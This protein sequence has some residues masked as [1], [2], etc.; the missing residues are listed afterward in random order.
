MAANPI[1]IALLKEHCLV[2]CLWGTPRTIY[3]RTRYASH[4]PLLQTPNPIERITQMLNVRSSSYKLADVLIRIEQRTQR[5]IVDLV[6]FNFQSEIKA[7][8]KKAK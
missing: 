2:V 1:N 5:E 6:F 4:R 3:E 7:A 8:I